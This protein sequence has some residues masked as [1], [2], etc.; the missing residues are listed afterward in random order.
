MT[1]LSVYP[2]F[3]LA[4]LAVIGAG[5]A[6]DDDSD[7]PSSL[8]NEPRILAI[9]AD[10][11]VVSLAGSA[12]LTALVADTRIVADAQSGDGT[13]RGGD[14]G[15]A[16]WSVDF[17]ACNPWRPMVDPARDCRPEDALKL[18]STGTS[19]E[20]A[21]ADVLGAFPPPEWYAPDSAD[22]RVDRPADVESTADCDYSFVEL[23]VVAEARGDSADSAWSPPR[24]VKRLR[25]ATR[26]ITR[27]NPDVESLVL[28]T[29]AGPSR[30][31]PGLSHDVSAVLDRDSLD[32]NCDREK[33]DT[34]ESVRIYLYTDGGQLGDA[35]VDIEY[36]D[37]GDEIAQ[38]TNWLAPDAEQVV[39]WLIA[40]DRDGGV[41][42]SRFD[43]RSDL[44]P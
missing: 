39:F 6:C 24:A 38:S 22:R 36:T 34:L 4:V 20:I 14:G 29:R 27:T 12:T 7:S 26:S 37:L 30:F 15:E 32:R 40:I 23:A 21:T 8:I 5:A 1:G 11:P 42:W 9:R 16:G 31:R 44:L 33:P 18:A 3:W 2:R 35:Y 13:A 19:A 10:P 43:L 25:F 28:D 41:G 17:R